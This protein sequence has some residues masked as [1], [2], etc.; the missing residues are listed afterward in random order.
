MRN[1]AYVVQA[2]GM[3]G[4]VQ[5]T[6][7]GECPGLGGANSTRHEPSLQAT[8]APACGIQ[9]VLSA[10]GWQLLCQN[11]KKHFFTLE[12]T[13]VLLPAGQGADEDIVVSSA[14][15]YVAA[16]N[17]MIGWLSVVSRASEPGKDE[18]PRATGAEVQVS[19]S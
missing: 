1:Q 9:L 2:G 15:A 3:G 13:T 11:V 18:R 16:L 8:Q 6:F 12:L 4:M 5:R 17:K 10:L 19:I 14:R 7:S